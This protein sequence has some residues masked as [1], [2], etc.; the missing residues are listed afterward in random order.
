MST[1]LTRRSVLATCAVVGLGGCGAA[2]SDPTARPPVAGDSA[3]PPVK[4]AGRAATPIHLVIPGIGVDTRLVRLGQNDDGT[5][6]VPT[7][8]E[9]AGWFE[10]GTVPGRRGSAVILGHVD[11]VDGPAVFAGLSSLRSTDRVRVV[12]SDDG[13]VEFE[14]IGVET[15]ANADFPAQRVYAGSRRVRALNLV[16]CGGEYDGERGG[17]QSNVVVFTRRVRA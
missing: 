12:L 15:Y 8:P 11:S 16:T 3:P 9:T 14:V 1:P 17:Y 5:V 4:S 6:E 10:L 2:T 13:L 7:A